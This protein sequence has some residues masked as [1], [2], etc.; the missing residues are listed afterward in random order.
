VFAAEAADFFGVDAVDRGD[1]D[2]GDGKGSAGVGLG[3]IAA[4]N[5]VDVGLSEST[6]RCE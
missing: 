1:F 3:D 6:M 4:A 5:E 2:S